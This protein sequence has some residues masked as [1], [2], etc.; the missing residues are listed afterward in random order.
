MELE[1]TITQFVESSNGKTF[2]IINPS[3]LKLV[4]K[5][6]SRSTHDQHM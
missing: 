6:T 4:A 2:D 3:T 1:L 5:G